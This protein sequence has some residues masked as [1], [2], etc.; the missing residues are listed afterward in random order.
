MIGGRGSRL[1]DSLRASGGSRQSNGPR[2]PI[3][4]VLAPAA[5]MARGPPTV[6][7]TWRRIRAP[8]TGVIAL[9]QRRHPLA[10]AN[11]APTG[12][13]TEGSR[14]MTQITSAA[15]QRKGPC[16]YIARRGRAATVSASSKA[17]P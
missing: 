1:V 13:I 5:G 14:G 9:G 11:Q 12:M 3:H 7:G 4:R 16:C 17:G 8:I 15:T 6:Q 10:Q 2:L